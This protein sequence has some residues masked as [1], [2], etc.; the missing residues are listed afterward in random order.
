MRVALLML[1]ALLMAFSTATAGV[2]QEAETPE[3]AAPPPPPCGTQPIAIARMQ[4]PSA[5]LLA[6]IHSRILARSFGCATRI[7][8]GDLAATGSAMGATGQPA[9]APE[10]WVSRITDIW[11]PATKAQKV[12]QVGASYAETTFEGWFIPEYLAAARP[13]LKTPADLKT[14]AVAISPDQKLK[15]FTCPADWGCSILNA[16][17]LRAHGLA[18]VLDMVTP[19]NRFELDTLIA[20]AVGR[21]EPFVLYYWQ[22][23]AVLSQF[24]F[25][26]LDLGSYEKDAFAC[27]GKASCAA[28]LP[29]G[30]APDPVVIALAEWVFADAPA[31]AGYFSR[32]AMPMAE[33]NTLLA[34]LNQPGQTVETVADTFVAERQDI[35]G[36]WTG[37]P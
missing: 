24:A 28:P 16:N 33:M 31:V 7:V 19:A 11:N 1:M 22:P 3:T 12:R 8:P 35:W 20:E 27:L 29:S 36:A 17:L 37:T 9:V 10:M 21:S 26:P 25:K 32:A 13:E 18:G 2:A 34:A 5:A 23:N 14:Q 6:E 4:W 15:F 30:F